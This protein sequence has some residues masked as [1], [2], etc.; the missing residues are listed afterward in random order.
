M[1]EVLE[2][3]KSQSFR[4]TYATPSLH[5]IPPFRLRAIRASKIRTNLRYSHLLLGFLF[6]TQ[7]NKANPPKETKKG[8]LAVR[9]YNHR[10]AVGDTLKK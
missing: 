8:N 5:T 3:I 2:M 9:A 6:F 7:I 10:Q 1:I 4:G